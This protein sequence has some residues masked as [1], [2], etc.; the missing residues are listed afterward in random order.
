MDYTFREVTEYKSL[1]LDPDHYIITA[2]P[3]YAVNYVSLK[4]EELISNITRE[5]NWLHPIGQIYYY[6]GLHNYLRVAL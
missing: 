4:H 2:L 5:Y 3:M 1:K 6:L